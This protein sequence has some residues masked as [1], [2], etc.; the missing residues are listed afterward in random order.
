MALNTDSLQHTRPIRA[1]AE[2]PNQ[3]DE[4]FDGI[5]YGKAAWVL[6]M[7]E[8]YVGPEVFR[9]G[10]NA[11]LEKHAYGNA[12]S[13]DFWNAIAEASHKPGDQ[14][15]ATFITQ[16]GAPLLAGEAAC[17]NGTTEVTLSQQRV[18]YHR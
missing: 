16:A 13:E 10:V 15:M 2:T 11:Y 4:L 18:Y 6:R 7:I 17:R 8:A 5:A 14:I 12:T 1:K 9:K 3:I